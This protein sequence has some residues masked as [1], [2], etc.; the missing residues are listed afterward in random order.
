MACGT[1]VSSVAFCSNS[2][3]SPV[4]LF[5]VGF[6]PERQEIF[7]GRF[8][9]C[10]PPARSQ[11]QLLSGIVFSP[12]F[13]KKLHAN[14]AGA[15]QI[16][17]ALVTIVRA[18]RAEVSQ[19][20]ACRAEV[21]RRRACRAE[22][23]RRRACRAEVLRRRACRAEVSRRR[24]AGSAWWQ[25]A[26]T[27]ACRAEVRRRR[28]CRVEVLRRRACRA[29][30]LR[31]R[32]TRHHFGPQNRKIYFSVLFGAIWCSL[33]PF[34]RETNGGSPRGPT[35]S[36]LVAPVHYGSSLVTLALITFFATRHSSLSDS[37]EI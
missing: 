16:N 13:A 24:I 23:R 12:D 2:G 20:R 14:F 15:M 36:S 37:L 33:V 6:D 22:V 8:G 21:L 18:R 30:V 34:R 3:G 5:C 7:P 27:S 28:A 31:R 4:F 9:S 29:E 35:I 11:R 25:S 1:F 17:S 32:I 26:R 10:L 19:R